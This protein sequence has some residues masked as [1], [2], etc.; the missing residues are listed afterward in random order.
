[1]HLLKKPKLLF[2]H[3]LIKHKIRKLT[4]GYYSKSIVKMR[5]QQ[6]IILELKF[7]KN[8]ESNI[9]STENR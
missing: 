3:E 6:Q 9:T 1:M 2:Y 8:I 5:K 7:Q 4:T